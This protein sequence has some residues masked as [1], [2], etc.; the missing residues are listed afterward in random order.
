MLAV[1]VT[2]AHRRLC[3]SSPR[4]GVVTSPAPRLASPYLG[5]RV[6]QRGRR[7][8]AGSTTGDIHLHDSFL[9]VF[10]DVGD[11]R[12]FCYILNLEAVSL[13]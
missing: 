9:P 7:G 11:F 4:R 12:I 10:N 1:K 13:R 8:T 3:S 2:N 5:V 6:A